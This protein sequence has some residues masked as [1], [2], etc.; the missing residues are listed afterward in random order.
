MMM[1]P[2][3]NSSAEESQQI[4][5][6]EEEQEEE[7][8]FLIDSTSLQQCP[9]KDN[10]Q[11]YTHLGSKVRKLTISDV[12]EEHIETIFSLFPRVTQLSLQ[13]LTL[14]GEDPNGY[15]VNLQSLYITDCKINKELVCLWFV[16]LAHSLTEI[17]IARSH[18]KLSLDNEGSLSEPQFLTLLPN[19]RHLHLKECGV[20]KFACPKSPSNDVLSRLELVAKKCIVTGKLLFLQ[21]LS[22]DLF[23]RVD[24]ILKQLD[25]KDT[26]HTLILRNPPKNIEIL[27]ELSNLSYLRIINGIT[28]DV[29]EKLQALENIKTLDI[30]CALPEVE[31]Q[32]LMIDD[33]SLI[34][35]LSYLSID[36]WIAIRQTDERLHRL[37]QQ[38]I[39]PTAK[40]K[41]DDRFMLK[42]PLEKNRELYQAMGKSVRY[43]NLSCDNLDRILPF[44]VKLTK[45]YIPHR[46]ATPD[47]LDLIPDGLK[48][49]DLFIHHENQS[50][51]TLFRRLNRTLTALEICGPFNESDLL[52]LSN[53]RELKLGGYTSSSTNITEFLKQNQDQM[54]RLEIKF[55][56]EDED[57]EEYDDVFPRVQKRAT[58][59]QLV[60]MKKLKILR[61]DSLHKELTLDPFD[62]PSLEELRL[63][64]DNYVNPMVVG[65]LIRDILKFTHLNTLM[66]NGLGDYRQLYCLRNLR[67]LEIYEEFLPEDMALEIIKN[68]PHL[69]RLGTEN[70]HFSLH[71]EMRMQEIIEE[72]RRNV[73]LYHC[74]WPSTKIRFGVWDC[75]KIPMIRRWLE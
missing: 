5:E 70:D 57:D 47:F 30:H 27:G 9:L 6:R 14:L 53:L 71:F 15:P 40:V 38:F 75:A 42:Y 56:E 61:L 67:C 18:Y 11:I 29:L 63:S 41:I 21:Y 34:H 35:I 8:E 66:I 74:V 3:D 16:Q 60:P 26:L 13:G 24:E 20:L 43:L 51:V 39:F 28:E 37:V 10:V 50:L 22:M 52:E 65:S 72:R 31:N 2:A 36:D 46:E 49:L 32:L 45:L 59:F 19:V 17:E 48:Q 7:I 1:K 68:L 62:L 64:F 12:D 58:K 4:V 33:D 69:E 25:C 73:T 23:D 44:F 55:F 54:E